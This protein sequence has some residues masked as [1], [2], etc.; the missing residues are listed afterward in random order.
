MAPSLTDSQR[1][2]LRGASHW[3]AILSGDRIT[4]V[5]QQKWRQW[6][7]A[8]QDH[9]W[10]WQQVE[11]LREQVQIIPGNIAAS[12]LRDSALTRRQVMKGLLLALSVGGG[13]QLWR[14]EPL[15]GLRADYR[16]ATGEIRQFYLA[17]GTALTLDTASAA[18][19]IF[20]S[21]ERRI[22]LLYGVVAITSGKDPQQR[23]LRVYTQ[24]AQL[25]ALGTAFTV[26][27][28]DG[29]TRLSVQQHAVAVRLNGTQRHTFIVQQQQALSFSAGRIDE[30]ASTIV[31][32][33]EWTR[34]VLSVSDRPL[35]EVLE[36]L[37]RYRP[38][39]LRCDPQVA[40]LRISGTF[41]LTDSDAAL[42]ALA[43]TLPVSVQQITRYWTVV[44]PKLSSI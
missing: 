8:H 43:Q 23:P 11:N 40:S 35:S 2:A 3:Y 32:S 27:Q 20:T 13:W 39:I 41:P 10:A 4:P 12:A 9:Q 22:E 18:N 17:E 24:Q 1:Q 33:A 21:S 38:G 26:E 5:Q 30:S 36:Q 25:T 19:V 34:G 7:E 29:H 42:Q 15:T 16:T 37:A 6:I 14:S 28:L 31:D 44:K